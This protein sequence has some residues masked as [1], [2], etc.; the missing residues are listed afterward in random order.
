MIILHL[1]DTHGLHHQIKDLP[2]GT[3]VITEASQT[4]TELIEATVDN[5]P[6]TITSR[7]VEVVVTAGKVA[8]EAPVVSFTN[9]ATKIDFEKIWKYNNAS[10]KWA[11]NT[12][13]TVTVSGGN[14]R[15]IY[16]ISRNDLIAGKEISGQTEG[17][18]KLTV[19]TV[20]EDDQTETYE[21]KFEVRELPYNNGNPYIVTEQKVDKYKDPIYKAGEVDTP[22]GAKDGGAI[23]NTAEESYELPE[24]GGAGTALFYLFGTVLLTCAGVILVMRRKK[25]V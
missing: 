1:S 14:Q 9:N 6:A 25:V 22:Y 2:A 21:Y 3:Y 19:R 12:S 16:T 10:M 15:Y 5:N 8:G 11:D 23:I 24:S 4:G 17:D 18:P 7:S 20:H 13:I